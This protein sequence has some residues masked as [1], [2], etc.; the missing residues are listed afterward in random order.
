MAMGQVAKWLIISGN[1]T[2]SQNKIKNFD[3][4][5]DDYDNVGQK[6]IAHR[7]TNIAFS[8]NF[9]AAADLGFKPFVHFRHGALRAF[10]INLLAKHVGRQ[11]LDNTSDKKRSIAD[12]SL[13]DL[14]AHYVLK[15]QELSL[16]HI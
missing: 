15:I 10:E 6:V 11:Y 3:E 1:M 13:F 8:P 7:N 14:R 9:I 4:Y 5:V 12:Y 2:F 16:I